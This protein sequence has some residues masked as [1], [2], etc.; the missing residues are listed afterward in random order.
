MNTRPNFANARNRRGTVMAMTAVVLPVL[1]ILA[2][3]AINGAHMQLTRTELS[4]A[5]DAAARAGGR[6]FSEIQTVDSAIDAAVSTA[7]MNDIYGEPLRLRSGD[8]DGEI[9]FGI[10]YQTGGFNSRYHFDKIPTG[11][12]RNGTV[13]SS[14]R[15]NGNRLAGS[16][17]GDVPLIIPGLLNT[18]RF[19]TKSQSVAMQVDRDISLILDRSGSMTDVDFDWASGESP[20]Y[21]STKDWGHAQGMLNKWWNNGWRYSYRSG[22]DSTTYQQ[23]VYED[24]YEKGPAPRT[25]WQDLVDAVDAFLDVLETTSQEEQV[26]LA[27]YSTSATLDTLLEKDHEVVRSRVDQLNTGGWTA[28]GQGM[29]EGI[30]GLADA[31]ARPFA[32]KTMVVM[33]DGIQNRTPWAEDV[34]QNLVANNL[35]VIHTVTFGDGAD[36]SD[37][38]EVAQIGGG[39]HYHAATGEDLVRIFEEIAN[40]LPTML[41]E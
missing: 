21:N 13:A 6:A 31:R 17:S 20:W 10:S 38:Q 36:Q 11:E 25:A 2:A 26:S 27:S 5:T 37:M 32:A 12:V 28:I 14:L 41:T 4:I 1:A 18:D 3:F 8:N 30:E 34:A 40:N 33:T 9:E 35:L 19:E 39:K 24:Y 7:A 16:L 22:W 29:Q 15:V 23:A